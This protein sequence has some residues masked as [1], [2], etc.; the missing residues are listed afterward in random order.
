VKPNTVIETTPG[1]YTITGFTISDTHNYGSL[2]V[3][4]VIQK[5]SNVGALKIASR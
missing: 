2:T 3:E 5:S 1:R 4:G